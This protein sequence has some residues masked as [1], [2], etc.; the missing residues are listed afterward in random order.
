MHNNI[1]GCLSVSFLI[2][3]WLIVLT[4]SNVLFVFLFFMVDTMG[5][6]IV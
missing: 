1:L 4:I 2:L 5:I 3:V 6:P